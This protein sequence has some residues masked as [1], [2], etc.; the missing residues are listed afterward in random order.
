MIN[1]ILNYLNIDP[2]ILYFISSKAIGL[3][4]SPIS[5]ILIT[6][7]LTEI[8][9]GY[10][11]TFASLLGIS[12]FFELGL[13]IIL[14]HFASHE[15]SKLNWD[16]N[17]KLVG[18]KVSLDIIKTLTQK[19][20]FW[21]FLASILMSVIIIF[22][23]IEIF[24]SKENTENID[25]Y[26]PWSLLII[27]FAINNSLIPLTSIIEGC[28]G[29]KNVQRLR[30]LQQVIIIPFTWVVFV[31]DGKLYVIFIE[32]FGYSIVL[33]YWFYSNYKEFIIQIFNSNNL[34]K[35]NI[36][37]FKDIFPLQWKI[38]VS[39]VSS[40]F[41]GYLF[42]PLLF[43]YSGEVVAGQMGLSLKITGYVYLFSMAWINTKIPK[44]GSLISLNK[45]RE[46]KLLFISSF[47]NSL[48]ASLFSSF[49]LIVLLFLLGFMNIEFTN[50][51]LPIHL[52]IIL[53]IAN[54][55]NVIFSSI[56]GYLRSFKKEPMLYA[57]LFLG[58]AVSISNYIASKYFDVEIMIYSYLIILLLIGLSTHIYIYLKNEPK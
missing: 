38:A 57:T 21:Y 37:W 36:S 17:G 19:S 4:Y 31:F 18:N 50:R 7:Y 11:F 1:K 53:C 25:L 47:K 13:G 39:W 35:K 23:G 9:Q 45:L 40:Y 34:F 43:H 29:V 12:I 56:S 54:I 32:Y 24:S 52:L 5:I 15:F 3:L 55:L 44:F 49:S 22:L 6:T 10:Y 48:I 30:F 58:I 27:F 41:L 51:L 46:L 2:A 20:F 16:E 8:E 14:T 42:V 33:F 28:G 26:L